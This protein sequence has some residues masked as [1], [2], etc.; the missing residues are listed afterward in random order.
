M[1]TGVQIRAA[2]NALRWTTEQLA[3]EAGVTSRTIKRFEASDDVPPSRTET[4]LTVKVALEAA[5]IEFV[6][7]PN[8][9]PGIR[10]STP[11]PT[12]PR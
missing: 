6:G 1:I 7:S 9:R 8:D 12:A 4:L 2:R 10:V 5:G 3:R 11:S